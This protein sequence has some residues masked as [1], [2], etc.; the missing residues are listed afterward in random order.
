MSD[1][2]P[3]SQDTQ[4]ASGDASS[5]QTVSDQS[6]QREPAPEVDVHEAGVQEAD[7]QE[8]AEAGDTKNDSDSL[9][10]GSDDSGNAVAQDGQADAAEAVAAAPAKA[11]GRGPAWLALLLALL[12]SG[13][14]GALGWL[15]WQDRDASRE[16]AAVGDSNQS[17]ID[18]FQRALDDLE[19]R[20]QQEQQQLQSKARN[21]QQELQQA[22]TLI[23]GQSRRLLSLTAT[24][25]DDWRLAEVE[26]LLRLAN[27]RI[28]TSKDGRTALN[29]L[30]AADEILV[31]LGDPRLYAVREAIANDR[32]ALSL[33]GQ[34]DLDGVFL[35]LSALAAQI[36]KLPLL[37]VPDFAS[38]SP[39][40]EP[41]GEAS[42][43]DAA[44][45]SGALQKLRE[46]ASSTWAE[47]K[48]LIVIQRQDAA[49]K[50]LLPPDQ[51]QYLRG[52]L[53]LL[54]NQAQL[55]LLDGRQT[56]YRES[57]QSAVQLLNDHFPMQEAANRAVAGKLGELAGVTIS[58]D[59]PDVS[60]SLLA[61]KAFIAEQHRLAKGT[62]S[63]AADGA[64]Q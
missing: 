41:G 11:P 5:A 52:N 6:D 9:P 37:S 62:A 38:R 59:Y 46:I 63:K 22:N 44:A 12:A 51:Q 29:L 39:A 1:N 26:Y 57:L 2:K 61:I 56:P 48:S 7:V 60:A 19:R 16:L 25:T 42:D 33:V 34:A 17:R 30:Q 21:L 45:S 3:E 58:A 64:K 4:P 50:P 10:P 54:I 18:S 47:M 55:A 28:L 53:R 43:T 36:D 27:Q 24:T 32:A 40:E 35:Q 20:M 8:A 23:E 13:G 49:V 14:A 31:E 15:W